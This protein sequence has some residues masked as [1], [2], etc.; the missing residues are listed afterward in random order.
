M[1]TPE[2]RSHKFTCPLGWFSTGGRSARSSQLSTQIAQE[3]APCDAR[4]LSFS[5]RFA[6]AQHPGS[7]RTRSSS[8]PAAIKSP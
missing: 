6:V 2:P 1:T 5:S 8:S 7:S 4:S 3:P